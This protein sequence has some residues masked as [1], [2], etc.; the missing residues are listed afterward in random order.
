M[1]EVYF[2]P[3]DES[4][5][6]YIKSLLQ[7]GRLA[8]HYMDIL[9]N[10]ENL[11][12][13]GKAFTSKS[14]DEVNNYEVYEQMGD[15]GLNA[16][17]VKYMYKRFPKL[18]CVDGVKI[19]ARLRINYGD[20]ETLYRLG[21]KLGFWP[22][23]SASQDFRNR[24]KKHL[25][26][27][28]FE[29]FIGCVEYLLDTYF[30]PGVGSGIIHDILKSVYDEIDISLKYEDLYDAKT[31]LKELFDR[32]KNELGTLQYRED[33]KDNIVTSSV[34]ISKPGINN[35]V[36]LG[37]ANIKA[38]AQQ[39]AAKKAIQYLE[40]RGFKKDIPEIYTKI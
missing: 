6:R 22:Y 12:E 9:V 15:I 38:D 14:A 5:V 19:V 24:M 10:E 2:A 28:V 23:I 27:D 33:K 21:D 8:P 13:F 3:R 32:Y 26:E 25:I 39:K 1:E 11:K 30:R 20:K 35:W 29:S 18:K 37:Q 16:F 40:S 4:F 31:R 7:R 36:F 17:I 34:I